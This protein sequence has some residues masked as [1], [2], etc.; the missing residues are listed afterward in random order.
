MIQD[1]LPNFEKAEAEARESLIPK[2]EK[3]RHLANWGF[4]FEKYARFSKD[5]EFIKRMEQHKIRCFK[6]LNDHYKKGL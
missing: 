5:P 1:N 4:R 2:T 6:M 3:Q